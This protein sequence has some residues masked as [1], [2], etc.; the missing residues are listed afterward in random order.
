MLPRAFLAL[1]GQAPDASA[2]GAQCAA[3]DALYDSRSGRRGAHPHLLFF[4]AINSVLRV[5]ARTPDRTPHPRLHQL[6]RHSVVVAAPPSPLWQWGSWGR[7]PPSRS[8]GSAGLRGAAIH[9]NA[10]AA[11]RR[12]PLRR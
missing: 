6:R 10:N 12:A 8:A 9:D 2:P 11:T 7:A 1:A 4:I 5:V 3:Q